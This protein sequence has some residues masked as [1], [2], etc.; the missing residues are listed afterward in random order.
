MAQAQ[1][2]WP[3][4]GALLHCYHCCCFGFAYSRAMVIQLW[5]LG[6]L[7]SCSAS[8][9]GTLGMQLRILADGA[10]LDAS[11]DSTRP[12]WLSGRAVWCLQLLGW[13]SWLTGQGLGQ[14]AILLAPA[15]IVACTAFSSSL[16]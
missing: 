10:M 6:V 1:P 8:F 3:R 15:T 11:G 2:F 14:L 13:T 16:L 5:Q 9:L 12:R 4:Q 7:A